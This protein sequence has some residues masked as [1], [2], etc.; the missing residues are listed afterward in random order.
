MAARDLIVEMA[1]ALGLD[2]VAML[3]YTLAVDFEGDQWTFFKPCFAELYDLYGFDIQE[4]AISRPL[5]EHVVEQVEA[6]RAVLVEVDSWFLPDTAG[7]AYQL[8]HAKTTIGV[9]RIDLGANRM[10]YFHNAGYF[11]VEGEDFRRVLRIRNTTN[12]PGTGTGQVLV[13]GPGL[14]Q[15]PVPYQAPVAWS[16]APS[17]CARTT[18]A[19]P[20]RRGFGRRPASA[21]RRALRGRG[22]PRGAR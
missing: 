5:A 12:T 1:H 19:R 10:G 18:P 3:P 22:S 7:T 2:P 14:A 4:L 8:A 21:R 11:E 20:R 17:S 9:N 6:G 13:P 16:V 15:V